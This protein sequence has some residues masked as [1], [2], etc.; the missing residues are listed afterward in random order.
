MPH[1]SDKEIAAYLDEL[2]GSEDGLDDSSSEVEDEISYYANA[3]QLIADLEE[4]DETAV[5]QVDSG[6]NDDLTTE[7]EDYEDRDPP[8]VVDQ[9]ETSSSSRSQNRP[10]IW[11]NR[12]FEEC[13]T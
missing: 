6:L 11:R 7:H 8:L 1:V 4:D 5:D 3:R 2:E 10:I 9:P 13:D 12:N